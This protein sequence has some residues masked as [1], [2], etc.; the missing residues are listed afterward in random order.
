[1][2]TVSIPT[3]AVNRLTKPTVG[4]TSEL[5]FI[6]DERPVVMCAAV[7]SFRAEESEAASSG[8]P[9]QNMTENEAASIFPFSPDLF[10]SYIHKTGFD[11]HVLSAPS[12]KKLSRRLCFILRWGAP[13]LHLPMTRDGYVL[14][15][16]LRTV[17]ALQTCTDD[18]IMTVVR[19]DAKHR[20]S[21]T[22]NED[23][24]LMVRA[25]HG[26]GIPGVEVVERD[27]TIHDAIGFIAHVT[28]YNAWSLIR[29]EGL[30][31]MDRSHIH[32][33]G[34]A[35]DKDEAVAGGCATWRRSD[36]FC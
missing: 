31:R 4:A 22:I 33:V 20:F 26:H 21:T 34:R 15:R 27:L 25:N 16:D 29:S 1:M 3:D 28:T 7:S 8:S 12:L 5:P 6:D 17:A 32:F 23:G 13:A 11:A 9:N 30:R 24:E 35:P 18:R 14:A 10:D 2:Q 19:R 36:D